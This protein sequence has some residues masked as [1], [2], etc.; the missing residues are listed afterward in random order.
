MKPITV[1]CSLVLLFTARVSLA[2]TPLFSTDFEYD[3]TPIALL[4]AVDLNGANNQVGLWSGDDFPEGDAYGLFSGGVDG[5]DSA[6]FVTDPRG[7]TM[8]FIDRPLDSAVHF[9]ELTESTPLS[10]TKFSFTTG[11]AHTGSTGRAD[12]DLFGLDDTGTES[13]RIRIGA[14]ET[15]QRL[16]YVSE[17]AIVFD[18]PTQSGVDRSGDLAVA[19]VPLAVSDSLANIS[20]T[21]GEVGYVIDFTSLNQ[22]NRWSSSVL[23]YNGEA[24]ELARIAISYAGQNV[25]SANQPGFYLDDL[26]VQEVSDVPEPTPLSGYVNGDG[27]IVLVGSGEEL[28]GMELRSPLGLLIPAE[29]TSADPFD[30]QLVNQPEQVV[31]GNVG[32]AIRIDGEVVTA[33][34]YA[35]SNPETDLVATW[36]N[37]SAVVYPFTIY[38]QG[39][40]LL[41]CNGDGIVDAGDLSCGCI[42]QS[43][44]D[45]LLA[46]LNLVEGDLDLDGQVAFG[47]FLIL[48]GNF[49][50]M[51][52]YVGGDLD[53]DGTV[54][55]GDFLILSSNFGKSAASTMAAVPEPSGGLAVLIAVALVPA[56]VRRRRLSA[57]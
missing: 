15:T 8:L 20:L 49:G 36:G 48:S 21:L 35:G 47:D 7:G 16:G 11:I 56:G 27:K 1:I 25:D 17:G 31:F 4:E 23:P 41:D 3:V 2:Q 13:F 10:G 29:G 19:E 50:Q 42:N 33:I 5:G 57:R 40:S 54:K 38:S 43:G 6:G 14:D 37:A 12:F 32:N 52:E 44:I 18:L 30:F 39:T 28:L 46:S 53:C 26:I 24:T 45:G 34:G 22:S 9:L 51:A 55:F